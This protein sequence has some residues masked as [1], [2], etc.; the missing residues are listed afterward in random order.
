MKNVRF[1]AISIMLCGAI[2][3][4][5]FFSRSQTQAKLISP[6]EAF[7]RSKSEKDILLLDVRTQEEYAEGHIANSLLIPIQELA[8]RV[9]E[10]LPYK[11]KT[12]IAYCRTGHRSGKATELL[13][14]KGFTVYNMEGGMIKWTDAKL[15]VVEKQ[16]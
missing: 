4:G 5:L 3:M 10:L 14:A 2:A 13:G 9:D 7:E 12:I 6:K 15:P 11:D 8:G 1:F 16:R